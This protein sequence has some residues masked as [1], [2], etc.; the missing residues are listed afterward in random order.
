MCKLK[1]EKKSM[2]KREIMLSEGNCSIELDKT[3]A[4]KVVFCTSPEGE[5]L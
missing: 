4:R 1:V 2:S 5:C 3:E